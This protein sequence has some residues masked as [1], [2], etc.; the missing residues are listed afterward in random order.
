MELRVIKNCDEFLDALANLSRE[1]AE[2]AL[3]E[4]LFE[5]QDC[6]FQTAKGL[7]FSYT[8][9]TNKDGMPGGE[10]F[11]SRKEKSITKSSVFRAFWIAREL[12]GNVSGPKKLK[13]YGSSYLFDIFKRIGIIKS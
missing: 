8:I 9:K 3:W 7:K 10:I 6:E 12:E 13:V 1:E 2:D 5:L 4:L 11:V